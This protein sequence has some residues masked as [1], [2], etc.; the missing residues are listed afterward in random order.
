MFGPDSHSSP[1]IVCRPWPRHAVK[2]SVGGNW[3]ASVN[4]EQRYGCPVRENAFATDRYCNQHA[5]GCDVEDFLAVSTPAGLS[6]DTGRHL[7]FSRRA[8]ERQSRKSPNCPT[9]RRHK[10]PISHPAGHTVQ[11]LSASAAQIHAEV[12][13]PHD[14]KAAKPFRVSQDRQRPCGPQKPLQFVKCMTQGANSSSFLRAGKEFLFCHCALCEADL[15][16]CLRNAWQRN[17]CPCGSSKLNAARFF[18]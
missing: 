6:A 12:A 11:N 5:A 7:P 15:P 3:G 2:T 17:F 14:T 8:G 10:P 1:E 4:L 9:R 18:R 16:C 13:S